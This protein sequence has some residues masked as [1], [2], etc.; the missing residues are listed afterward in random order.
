MTLPHP[1]SIIISFPII[2]RLSY[3]MMFLP[4]YSTP[5]YFVLPSGIFFFNFVFFCYLLFHLLF[6]LLHFVLVFCTAVSLQ[7]QRFII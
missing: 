2:S 7:A 4:K 1:P 3:G 6:F 5:D